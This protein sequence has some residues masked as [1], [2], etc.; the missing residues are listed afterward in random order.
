MENLIASAI[1]QVTPEIE[2]RAYGN[3]TEVFKT[4]NN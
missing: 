3:T 2:K 4:R 1:V